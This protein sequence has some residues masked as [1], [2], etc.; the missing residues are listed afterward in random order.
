MDLGLEP[1]LPGAHPGPV[2][3]LFSDLGQVFIPL[4]LFLQL[5]NGALTLCV[6]FQNQ[7]D[8]DWSPN[9]AWDE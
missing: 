8:L 4:T 9:S 1:G 2:A 3:G 6:G 5:E 7:E